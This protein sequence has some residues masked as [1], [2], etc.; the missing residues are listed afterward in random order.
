M[1]NVI[2]CATQSSVDRFFS[3]SISY[4]FSCSFEFSLRCAVL[5]CPALP[6]PVGVLCLCVSFWW[7]LNHCDLSWPECLGETCRG[8]AGVGRGRGEIEGFFFL[9]TL[10]YGL[11][12]V[13]VCCGQPGLAWSGR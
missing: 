12:G 7:D 9:G 10:R 8:E 11:G 4:V 2:L 1:G 6:C 13:R 5:C 3:S